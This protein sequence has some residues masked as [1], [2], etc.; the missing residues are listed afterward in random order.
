MA[1][2]VDTS[3]LIDVFE[4]DPEFG[5][6]SARC[7]EAHAGQGL[8][9]CP[10][11][12]VEMSPVCDGNETALTT[13]L[14]QAGVTWLEPWSWQDT[15]IAFRLWSA[16]ILR[17]RQTRAGRR[18]VA[19]VLIGAFASRFQGLITRNRADFRSLCP[20]LPLVSP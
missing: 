15:K 17:K 10:V 12:F 16:C 8:L 2:V 3:V 11:T 4:N 13:F 14:T 20:D 5:L 19:D 1:W 9:I 18:P 6:A 7:L